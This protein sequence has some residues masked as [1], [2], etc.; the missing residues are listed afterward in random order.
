EGGGGEERMKA[1]NSPDRAQAEGCIERHVHRGASGKSGHQPLRAPRAARHT[2][3]AADC[4]NAASSLARSEG[5]SLREIAGSFFRL[6]PHAPS[7][8]PDR[9]RVGVQA[10][11]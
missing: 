3:A 1:R 6:P 8:S 5:F 7:A 11:L 4:D 10:V 9:E 2:R